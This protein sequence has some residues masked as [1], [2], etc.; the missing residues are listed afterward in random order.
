MTS[1]A[2]AAPS[3]WPRTMAPP[4]GFDASSG[5]S[6]AWQKA[7][8]WA[9]EDF[10]HLHAADGRAVEPVEAI[11]ELAHG[12]NRRLRLLLGRD[13]LGGAGD[14]GQRA[15]AC[16]A[17]STRFATRRRPWRRRRAWRA[18]CRASACRQAARTGSGVRGRP[19]RAPRRSGRAPP[20]A[21]RAEGTISPTKRR[22][23]RATAGA[24]VRFERI[25]VLCAR[26]MPS[27]RASSS[28]ASKRR[29]SSMS[30]ARGGFEADEV[31]RLV[32]ALGLGD[33]PRRGGEGFGAAGHDDISIAGG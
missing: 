13:A 20:R 19:C 16:R 21:W 3:G 33:A 18:C 26:E 1:T 11:V 9:A 24:H 4:S 22:A 7:M 17:R 8:A 5:I 29:C 10:A 27:E 31:R 2:P 23:S 25:G 32:E 12:G 15:A 6:S 30:L 28:D 14:E